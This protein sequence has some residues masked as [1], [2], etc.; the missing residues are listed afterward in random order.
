MKVRIIIDSTA[1]VSQELRERFTILPLT[2]HFGDEEYIDGVTITN[3][4]FYEKLIESDVMPATSQA[5]PFAFREAFQHAVDAGESVVAITI[6]SRLSGTWQSAMIAAE[7]FPGR[8][9]VVDSLNVALGSG[10]LAEYALR[11]ADGGMEA[12]QIAE[13]VLRERENVRLIAMLNTLEFLRRGG[14]ISRTTA[15][16]G[17]LLSIK[18]VI[19]IQ[20]GEIAI[21]GK[22]RGSRHACNLLVKEIQ[23][24]GGVDF[25]KPLML[26]YTGLSDQMLHKY[27]RDSAALWEGH[28]DQ[29]R[30]ASIGSVIGTHAGPDAI[31][32]AFFK[33]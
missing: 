24:S 14:R 13:C 22:A 29:L 21:L 15:I 12:K 26:G 2:L 9:F 30:I 23:N 1:D 10:V 5:T 4:E 28:E 17:E 8:V 27:I 33:K 32:V 31:A 25:E 20:D 11:L 16:A 19:T 3:R 7:D 18:P 6:S